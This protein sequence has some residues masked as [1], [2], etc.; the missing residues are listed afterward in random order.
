MGTCMQ[1]HQ[2]GMPPINEGGDDEEDDDDDVPD[3]VDG[4]PS[5]ALHHAAAC[6]LLGKANCSSLHVELLPSSSAYAIN[7]R[8]G[9]FRIVPCA[10]RGIKDVIHQLF[11]VQ[12]LMTQCNKEPSFQ[13]SND[14]LGRFQRSLQNSIRG[15]ILCCW[16]GMLT[17]VCSCHWCHETSSHCPD[18]ITTVIS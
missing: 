13:E 7:A 9:G 12:V 5:R 4:E 15:C 14:R 2:N 17:N 10:A 3:L 8:S 6:N 1:P 11:F 18:A 16:S